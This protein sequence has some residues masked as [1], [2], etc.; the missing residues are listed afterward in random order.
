MIYVRNEMNLF[1]LNDN[2]MIILNVINSCGH[3]P[4]I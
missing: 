3:N 4:Q 1:V 2:D